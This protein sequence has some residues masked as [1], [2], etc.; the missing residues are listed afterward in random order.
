MKPIHLRM[1]AFGAFAEEIEIP[2]DKIGN[3]GIFLICGD[4]G[5][6]KTTIFDGIC[7]ALFGESSG[8]TRGVDTLRS[9]FASPDDKTSV[10]LSFAHKGKEY[11]VVRNPDYQRPKKTGTGTTKENKEAH[12]YNE[13][14]LLCSGY[15][16]VSMEIETLLGVDAKQFKQIAMIAQGEFL[17]LLHAN[18]VERG[19]I[20]QKVFHT[21]LF[22]RFQQLLKEEEKRAKDCFDDSGKNIVQYLKQL[23]P[24]EKDEKNLLYRAQEWLTIAEGEQR[25]AQEIIDKQ[26]AEYAQ[27]NEK[28]NEQTEALA[29]AQEKNDRLQMVRTLQEEKLRLAEKRDSMEQEQASLIRGRIAMDYIYP[30]DNEC[31]QLSK[32]RSKVENS[33]QDNNIKSDKVEQMLVLLEEEKQSFEEREKRL[34]KQKQLHAKLTEELPYFERKEAIQKSLLEMEKTLTEHT[35]QSE[36]LSKKQENLLVEKKEIEQTLNGKA[37]VEKELF[38]LTQEISECEKEISALKTQ[39]ETQKQQFKLDEKIVRLR[40]VYQNLNKD[41][42]EKKAQADSAEQ[43]FLAEQAG[44]LATGLEEGLACPVCGA[45]HHP[46]PARL[47]EGAPTEAVLK[48]KRATAEEAYSTCVEVAKEGVG[49]AE[50]KEMLEKSMMQECRRLG[51]LPEAV[52]QGK[53]SREDENTQRKAKLSVLEGCMVSFGEKEKRLKGITSEWETMVEQ[54]AILQKEIER[55]RQTIAGQKSEFS[56]L[57][58][59][60]GTEGMEAVRGQIMKIEEDILN[61]GRKNTAFLENEKMVK[62]EQISLLTMKKELEL[63]QIEVLNDAKEASEKLKKESEKRGFHTLEDYRGSLPE[64][65]EV[66]EEAEKANRTYFSLLQENTEKLAMVQKN[67]GEASYINT[68]QLQ[69][70]KEVV[71][72]M[73]E[74]LRQAHSKDSQAFAIR[75]NLIALAQIEQETYRK[76]E[77]AYLP[78]LELSKTASGELSGQEKITFET[79]V[80]GFYFDQVLEMANLRFHEMTEGR[81]LLLRARS[82]SNKQSRSGLEIEVMDY[83]TG[84]IRSVKS[85]SGGE[86]FKASLSLA[87]GLS[88]VIQSYAG[89]VEIQTMFIDEGFGALDEQ[90]R[91]QAVTMLQRLSDGNRLVGIISHVTELKDS[92]ERKIVVL[93]SPKGSK[94]SLELV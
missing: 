57:E 4:T 22:A 27:L 15:Q 17:K 92:I 82:A 91:E 40:E 10:S 70:E 21:K 30:L 52:E 34:E 79:F 19:E 41:W 81:Y 89:G 20:F 72:K 24:Q 50:R 14:R 88:D 73:R 66:L 9:D 51:V 3:G 35:R 59:R 68:A 90:S 80:Q 38:L 33:I 94:I 61:I 65:R 47:T 63:Q 77:E 25:E 62:E 8:M 16:Q 85:L 29:L 75:K 5:A 46:K 6:G 23:F 42:K 28:I 39:L 56:A 44:I 48:A 78:I 87:L 69:E 67:E 13:E 31:I 86:S 43:A 26:D 54:L 1:S 11:L 84:K 53:N 12:L 7:F 37:S 83:Y 76:A 32:K 74:A 55:N 60:L 93:K 49:L 45:T 2:F 64:S 36:S 71:E 58:S 18:S